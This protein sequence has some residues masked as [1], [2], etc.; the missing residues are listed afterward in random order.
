M[1]LE[2]ILPYLMIGYAAFALGCFWTVGGFRNK[3]RTHWTDFNPDRAP[4]TPR[5]PLPQGQ[6]VDSPGVDTRPEV[7]AS[8][9]GP[10]FKR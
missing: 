5:P 9:L 7:M 2:T 6:N 10:R 4:R 3:P 1:G 8:M